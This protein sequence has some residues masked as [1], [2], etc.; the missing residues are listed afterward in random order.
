MD[1]LIYFIYNNLKK[2][3]D[4][5][6]YTSNTSKKKTIEDNDEE[7]L[8]N[9]TFLFNE[10]NEKSLIEKVDE[11]S[12]LEETRLPSENINSRECFAWNS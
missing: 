9:F 10:L 5:V 6:G 3:D 12:L 1:C 4:H 8:E 2:D 7:L 11:N